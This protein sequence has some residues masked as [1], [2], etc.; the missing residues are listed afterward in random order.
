MLGQRREVE[1]EIS[2]AQSEI[3]SRFGSTNGSFLSNQTDNIDDIR[4]KLA[5]TSVEL[6]EERERYK[7]QISKQIKDIELD[8]SQL[9]QLRAED[10]KMRFKIN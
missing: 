7:K 9:E 3:S 5:T 1:S 4:R 2:K 6:E 8:G 10:K